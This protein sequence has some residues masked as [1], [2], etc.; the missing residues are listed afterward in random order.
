MSTS[1][2]GKKGGERKGGGKNR[3]GGGGW[4]WWP[5]VATTRGKWGGGVR[6]IPVGPK[7]ECLGASPTWVRE[8]GGVMQN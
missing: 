6:Q 7:S 1:P 3:G 5:N 8:V 2:T 4:R